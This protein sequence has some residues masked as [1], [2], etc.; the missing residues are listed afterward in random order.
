MNREIKIITLGD[1]FKNIETEEKAFE[2]LN[3]IQ[4]LQQENQQLK[5]QK[6]D[7]VD[8]LQKEN[9]YSNYCNE[10]LR[11]KI[12]NLKYKNERLEEDNKRLKELCDKY[13][14]EHSTTFNYWKQL[15][16]E[17]YKSRCEKAIEYIENNKKETFSYFNGKE[18]EYRNF[19]LCC[20][21]NDLLN[22]LKGS[23]VNE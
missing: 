20:E 10:E 15:I 1:I 18:Y 8:E 19:T 9:E 2:F 5:K 3:Y 21:P 22:I 17:D 4:K 6:D 11:K 7:V 16:K 14:E 12:T 23:G 13:E